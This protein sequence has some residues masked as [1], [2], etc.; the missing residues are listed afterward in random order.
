M[1][2]SASLTPRNIT[3]G[4]LRMGVKQYKSLIDG[5]KTK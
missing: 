5:V 3:L 4:A 2:Q 1:G